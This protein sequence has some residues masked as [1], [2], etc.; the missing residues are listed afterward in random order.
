[1]GIIDPS[2]PVW[3]SIIFY[4]IVIAI[5]LITKPTI[6]Y[7]DKT[8]RFKSF[9]LGENKTLCSFPVVS[10]SSVILLYIIFLNI[11]IL[12]NYLENKN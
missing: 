4:I 9:G 7:C 10:L 11:E 5:L 8:K 1:M 2:T 3:N 12:N 6:M